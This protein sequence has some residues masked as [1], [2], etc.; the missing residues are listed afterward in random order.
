MSGVRGDG[1]RRAAPILPPA[2]AADDSAGFLARAGEVSQRVI[3]SFPVR[4][5][6]RFQQRNGLLLAS[7]TS[8]QAVFAVFAALYI[9]FAVVGIWLGASPTAIDGVIG[10]VNSYAPGLVRVDDA[11]PGLVPA[12]Q[13]RDVAADSAGLLSVTGL[14]A[15]LAFTWT[16]VGWIT[17][18]RSSVRDIFRLPPVD[19]N[20]AIVKIWDFVAAIGFALLLFVGAALSTVGTSALGVVF[21]L[22][23]WSDTSIWYDLAARAVTIT[24]AFA[25]DVVM[26]VSLFRFLA[27]TDLAIRRILPGALI[28]GAGLVA[29]QLSAGW[30]IGRAPANPLVATFAVLLGLLLWFR[31][32]M[33]VILVSAAWVAE[34]ADDAD[35]AIVAM[36]EHDHRVGE[37]RVLL[38]AA[39]VRLRDRQTTR[40]RAPW[41]RQGAARRSVQR[42]ADELAACEVRLANAERLREEARRRGR[43]RRR[44]DDPVPTTT[45]SEVRRASIGDTRR[46]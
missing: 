45:T 25:I 13:I 40:A 6:Q 18:L 44:S 17:F 43:R 4:V 29:L 19:T 36:S 23:G 27:G 8:D 26:L 5:W 41:Y 10:V 30:L 37:A 39:R 7:G 9:V 46:G 21:D 32:A 38:T 20:F 42:A 22:V 35:I 28:G 3:E 12:Q 15:V 14:L 33:I 16:A 34:A 2:D 24:V 31:L 11:S 1:E